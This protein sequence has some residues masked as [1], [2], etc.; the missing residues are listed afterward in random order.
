MIFSLLDND[1][2]Q[3]TMIAALFETDQHEK[4]ATF[5]GFVRKLPKQRNFLVFAGL[6]VLLDYLANDF[7]ISQQEMVY[8]KGLPQFANLSEKFWN[9]L[10]NLKFT[11]DIRA[12]PEGT[13][14]FENEP[15]ISVTGPLIQVILLE[16]IA[17]SIL[18]YSTAVASKA[19]RVRLAAGPSK[20]LSEFGFRRAPGPGAAQL[21]SRAAII[22]GFN[23]TSNVTAGFEYGLNVTGTMA[24]SFIMAHNTEASAFENYAKVFPDNSVALIDTYEI[25]TGVE[26]ALQSMGANLKAVRLDSGDKLCLSRNI[27]QHLDEKGRK[28]VKIIV[29]DDMN[30][31]KIK[32]LGMLDAPIDG[33]GV[34]TE[35]VNP[36]PLGGVFKLV[37]IDGDDGIAIYKAKLSENKATYPGKKQVYRYL[38]G[39]LFIGDEIGL[40]GDST[41]GEPLLC[42]VMRKG[43]NI[44]HEG[45]DEMKARCYYNIASLHS[46]HRS[47]DEVYSANV[48]FSDN[49]KII[50]EQ[51]M[52]RK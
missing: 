29:S 11:C 49:L 51:L 25:A 35:L 46:K 41:R 43:A 6:Q 4:I 39:E 28:D 33:Y 42:E 24:H 44:Y 3:L 21:A 27:R 13:V 18:N 36:G 48:Q 34:G 30:E 2:Y 16:T 40:L 32:F 14:F 17:L 5:E 22:G 23:S 50:L 45:I 10:Y 31:D 9:Y 12:M 7:G 38:K 37:Q 8:L 19:A 52:E 26:N 47:I 1:L 15:F 20:S